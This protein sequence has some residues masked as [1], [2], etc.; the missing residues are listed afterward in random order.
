MMKKNNVLNHY[1]MNLQLGMFAFIMHRI[2]GVMLLLC[3]V[4]YLVSL[5]VIH[6]GTEA[7]DA[8]L[9]IYDLPVFHAI[10]SV[11]VIALFWHA[12]N[13]LRILIIDTLNAVYMQ[14]ALTII[15]IVLFAAGTLFYLMH[16]FPGWIRL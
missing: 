13:G 10:G 5:S 9:L 4:F 3:G 1:R 16:I 7:F 14:R 12:L 15:V 8:M 6:F 11:F 2:T